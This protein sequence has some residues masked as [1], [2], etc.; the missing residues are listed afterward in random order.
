MSYDLS[1]DVYRFIGPSSV[2]LT[3]PGVND[4]AEGTDSTTT[5]FHFQGTLS[6]GEYTFDIVTTSD[7]GAV[8][9]TLSVVP[10]P[11]VAT[12]LGLGVMYL[13]RRRGR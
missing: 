10:T 12:S 2:S 7:Q 5:P 11:E 3:G 9:A 13:L 4:L 6:P 8:N 1:G